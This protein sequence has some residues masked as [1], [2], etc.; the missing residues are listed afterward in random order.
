MLA[1]LKVELGE[2][3]FWKGLGIQ[4]FLSLLAAYVHMDS[5]LRDWQG[6][7]VGEYI[8]YSLTQENYFLALFPF[9]CLAWTGG[10]SREPCRYPLLV[11]YRSRME[12][13]FIRFLAKAA[14]PAAALGVHIGA[15]LLMG[16]SLPA[17]PQQI[18]VSSGHSEG[19]ILM[20]FL[21]LFCFGCVILLFYELMLDG[22]GNAMLGM[23]LTALALM[24]NLLAVKLMLGAV[25]EW[26]PW[27]KAAYT[28]FGQERTGYRFHGFYWLF[29]MGLLF[30]WAERLN[31]RKDY[32]FE[33]ERRVG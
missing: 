14:F 7:S 1:K 18:F 16:H 17:A 21:N 11:R 5:F 26:T 10:K 3:Y 31:G 15:L 6:A 32:V 8:V 9:L 23:M 29:L 33:E 19:I 2:F 25:V 12:A 30:W 13:F 20:Q 24:T 28:L 22:V 27:G 4:A